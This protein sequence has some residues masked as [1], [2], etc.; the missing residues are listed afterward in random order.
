MLV[1]LK[2]P[3]LERQIWRN[4]TLKIKISKLT[5][6]KSQ[7]ANEPATGKPRGGSGAP[8]PLGFDALKPS[9]EAASFP[10]APSS[11]GMFA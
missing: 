10:K 6:R 8:G 2:W 3:H 9:A 4:R 11:L 1:Q 5:N 7:R